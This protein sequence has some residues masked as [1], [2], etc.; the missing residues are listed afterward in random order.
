MIYFNKNRH[1]VYVKTVFFLFA[2]LSVIT[3]SQTKQGGICFRIGSNGPLTKLQ[4]LDNLFISHH[5]NKFCLSLGLGLS[6]FDDADYINEIKTLQA[7]GHEMMDLTPYH[8][9]NYFNTN[10]AVYSVGSGIDHINGTGPYKVCLSYNAVNTSDAVGSGTININNNTLT[11]TSG[12]FP[13]FLTHEYYYLYIPDLSQ[14]VLVGSIIS[15]TQIAVT[16]AWGDAINLGTY[17]SKTYY[18]FTNYNIHMTSEAL[19]ILADESQRLASNYGISIPTTWIQ[20]GGANSFL[21]KEEVK[22]SFGLK[23][24]TAGSVY[25]NPSLKVYGEYDPDGDKRYAMNWGDFKED[26]YSLDSNKHLIADGIAKHHVL[27]GHA[28]FAVDDAAWAAYLTQVGELLDWCYDKNIPVRTYSEWENNLYIEVPDAAEN[29]MPAFNVDLNEDGIP[30][31]YAKGADATFNNDDGL[32]ISG[33]YNYSI[34]TTGVICAVDNL[35]GLYKGDNDFEI[36]IKGNVGDIVRATFHGNSTGLDYYFDFTISSTSW[37]VY[38]LSDA[39]QTDNPDGSVLKIPAGESTINITIRC[40]TSTGTDKVSS[41]RF[42]ESGSLT[43]VT[44]NAKVF[45]Q[46][47]Y[48]GGS[49]STTLNTNSFLPTSQP[50]SGSPWTYSGTESVAGTYYTSHTDVVDWILV[51]LRTGTAAGTK[52]AERAA[53]IKSDGTITDLDGSSTVVFDGVSTGSYYIVIKHRN[54][55][56]I[57]SASVVALSGSSAQYDFTTAQAQAY[58]TN[59]MI[60]LGSGKYGMISGDGNKDGGIYGED[61]ILYQTT[62]GNEGYQIGDYNL[63]GGV[64]GEDYILYQVNQGYETLVP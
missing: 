54:H 49:M 59:A 37:K 23:G 6:P 34:G 25:A 26:A 7:N 60:S 11:S 18:Y 35:G 58:G 19:G 55:L 57:M 33:N 10:T 36:Y 30:D 13:D 52:V 15:G 61:Y 63:D 8:R 44:V 27:M 39:T 43:E 3:Y 21:S 28:Y 1:L 48:S 50:Y 12:N 16:D 41:M 20:P 45:L 42:A 51:E 56:A 64:Y 46:G 32:G 38:H 2:L 31:G 9:T 29:I 24:Y 47:P 62:Q 40:E 53:F 22:A 17:S 4:D 5:N 14:L